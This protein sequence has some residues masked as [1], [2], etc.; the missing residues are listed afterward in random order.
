MALVCTFSSSSPFLRCGDQKWTQYSK[1]GFSISLYNGIIIL[2]VLFTIPFVKISS[3]ELAFFTVVTH[4]VGTFID[5]YT[6]IHGSGPG[7][8]HTCSHTHISSRGKG[9][10]APLISSAESEL[11]KG[12]AVLP[13]PLPGSDWVV[14]L[15]T[16]DFRF[17]CETGNGIF[18]ALQGIGKPGENL[19][20]WQVKVA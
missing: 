10:S 11:N 14:W 7:S 15:K 1:S 16:C 20:N 3:M 9:G 19:D 5:L 4:W 18:N 2:A 13:Q 17:V 8:L 12:N 6:I